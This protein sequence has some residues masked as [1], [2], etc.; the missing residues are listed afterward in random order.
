LQKLLLLPIQLPAAAAASQPT[1]I[2]IFNK[3]NYIA[4]EKP[5]NFGK[6]KKKNFE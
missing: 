6:K 5:T 1:E 4:E 2:N 3:N